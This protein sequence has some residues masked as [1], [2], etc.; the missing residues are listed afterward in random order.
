MKNRWL[1]AVLP[2]VAFW[3]GCNSSTKTGAE[4]S[5][6]LADSLQR[7][8]VPVVGNVKRVYAMGHFFVGQPSQD[9]QLYED[10]TYDDQG[11]EI[12]YVAY[13]DGVGTRVDTKFDADGYEI[14]KV[15]K[16]TDRTG[17]LE[18][19]SVWNAD[20]TEQITEE[21]SQLDS[22]VVRKAIRKFDAKGTLIATEEEDRQVV[23]SPVTYKT[24]MVLDAAGRVLEQR[25]A[26]QGKEIVGI[27]YRY[28]AQGNPLEIVRMDSEGKPSQTETFEY[29][30]QSRKTVHYL[31][32]HGAYLSAKQLEARYEY[33]AQGRLVR[34]VHYK[35]LCDE[36]GQAAGKCPVSETIS[37]T[38]DT[39]GRMLT[40]ERDPQAADRPLMKKK[41]HY[42]GKVPAK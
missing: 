3:I 20:H 34:E 1:V 4:E 8:T 31:Q 21:F 35:G 28:D 23:E 39:E 10:F 5:K 9:W 19:R 22:R 14:L 27:R 17:T 32:D 24:R 25:E 12:G 41:F 15:R 29:D 36:N 16:S 13:F 26:V 18:Y 11:R 6:P 7:D 42:H 37:Y 30:A 38:Y 40:E 2:V 33:D